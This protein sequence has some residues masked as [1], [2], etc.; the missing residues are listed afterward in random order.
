MQVKELAQ[1]CLQAGTLIVASSP[2]FLVLHVLNIEAGNPLPNIDT[3]AIGITMS[4]F[5][6]NTTDGSMGLGNGDLCMWS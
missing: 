1:I 5:A 4:Y 6:L 2:D 3:E